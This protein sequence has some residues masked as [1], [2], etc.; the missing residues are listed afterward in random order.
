MIADGNEEKAEEIQ[1]KYVHTLGNLTLTGYNSTLG[2][3]SF[4]E[5]KNRKD[6]S[7]NEVGY[8]NGLNINSGIAIHEAPPCP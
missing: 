1:G 2:N 7:G 4:K 3:L 6:K 5:K 8:L